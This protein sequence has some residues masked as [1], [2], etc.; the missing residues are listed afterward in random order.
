MIEN[1]KYPF[2]LSK[3]MDWKKEEKNIVIR[4]ENMNVVESCVDRHSDLDK[5]ALVFEDG[6]RKEI[7]YKELFKEVNKFANLFKSLGVNNYSKVF[8]FL[9]KIPE[10][11]IGM[12]GALKAGGIVV[13]LFEAFQKDGLKLRLERG[14]AQIIVTNKELGE[15]IDKI[16][17]KIKTLENILIVD[18]IEFKK[19]L[20]KQEDKFDVVLKNKKETGMMIFTSSTAGTPVAG[21]EIPHYGLVQ[22]D[23]TSRVVLDL[24]E[25]DN[26][27]CTAHPGWV[28]GSIYGILAP[29]S[30]GCTTY[31]LE[32]RFD[33]KIWINFLKKN[34]ISVVYTAPTALRMLKPE[35]KKQD[36]S[37]VRNIC[38]VGEA[39]TKTTY[40]FYKKL[41][42]DINDSYWQTE[43]GAIVIA[44]YGK[45]KAGALGL[46]VG[47]EA[48]IKDGAIAFKKGWPAMMTGIYKHK[49]M[50]KD[51][52][53]GD[54]FLTNDLAIKDKDCYF[55]FEGRKDDIIKTSG[56]RVSPI[57][58]ESI[59][60]KHPAVKEA[61]VIGVSDKIKGSIIKAFVVLNSGIK[62]SDKLKEELS[63]YAKQDYAGHAYPKIIEFIDK[64]P[65]TNSGKI[66]RMKL[67][68]I[69]N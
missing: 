28:T 8:F 48:G 41:G 37:G 18:S 34:K 36:L 11:Y 32:G 29:L 42:V 9:P 14:D 2:D 65:K 19:R 49:K 66:I 62:G 5:L 60:M 17:D 20:E 27:W 35:I 46:A 50:Y 55:F 61:G 45:K 57:E 31:V 69:K 63:M 44:N 7:S 51:Y 21:I 30:I 56:E 15:R 40:D 52:F 3:N 38:S 68:E 25:D 10:M 22:Q 1:F 16:K 24:K 58:I 54:W 26:Y 4:G 53:D 43:T 67:R 64:L 6:C 59:L 23:Y 33:A 12:L 39:L 13:P 47:V